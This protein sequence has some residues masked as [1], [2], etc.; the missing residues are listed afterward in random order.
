MPCLKAPKA[1]LRHASVMLFTPLTAPTG[2]FKASCSSSARGI[3]KPAFCTK[4]MPTACGKRISFSKRS[5]K[6][7]YFG[8]LL[9][10]LLLNAIGIYFTYSLTHVR[11]GM[12]TRKRF[13]SG[14]LPDL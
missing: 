9:G 12:L 14:V 13:L 2:C 6:A 1:S 11:L 8:E 3:A 5:S 10:K 7:T 4:T